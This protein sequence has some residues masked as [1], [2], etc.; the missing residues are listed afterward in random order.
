MYPLPNFHISKYAPVVIQNTLDLRW[1]SKLLRVKRPQCEFKCDKGLNSS[2]ITATRSCR[3]RKRALH[4][5]AALAAAAAAAAAI[6][7]FTD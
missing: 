6:R 4:V 3:T 5:A 1:E 2:T 7:Q